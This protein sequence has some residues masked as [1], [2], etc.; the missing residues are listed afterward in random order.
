LNLPDGVTLLV[1]ATKIREYLLSPT[2][3]VGRLK[4]VFFGSLG[5]G[6]DSP[7]DLAAALEVHAASG[8]V[9]DH[10]ITPYGTKFVVEG[11][12]VGPRR[13]ARVRSVWIGEGSE[14][15]LRLITSYPAPVETNDDSGT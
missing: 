8:R 12:L 5:F 6:Q 13:S 4:A 3:P 2:H 1:E 10:V 7:G 11:E 14:R 15:S 9:V